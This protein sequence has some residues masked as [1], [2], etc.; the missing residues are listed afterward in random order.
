MSIR[1]TL[2]KLLYGLIHKV[3]ALRDSRNTIAKWYPTCFGKNFLFDPMFQEPDGQAYF[4]KFHCE[5]LDNPLTVNFK[6]FK[7]DIIRARH[8]AAGSVHSVQ[9]TEPSALPVAVTGIPLREST[10]SQTIKVDVEGKDLTLGDL[11]SERYYYLPISAPGTVRLSSATDMIVGNPLPLAQKK[12]HQARMVMTIFMD[13]FGWDVLNFLN[14]ERDV[15][16]LARFFSKGTVF[17]QCFSASNWT[18]A[19]VGSI[20]SG[21]STSHHNMFHNDRTDLLLGDDYKVLPEYFHDDGYLTLQVCGN[22]RKSPAYGFV[23]GYDRTVYRKDI[24]LGESLETIY[25]HVRAFPERDHFVWLTIMDVHHTIAGVPDLTNQ[26]N[27]PIEA[28]D[29][30][31]R[32]GKSPRVLGADTRSIARYVQDFKRADFYLGQLFAFLEERYGDDEMLV[33]LVSDHGPGFLSEN[34][35]L[36]SS[37]KTHVPF[38]L[39]GRNVPTLRTSE[40]IQGADIL[41]SILALNGWTSANPIDGRVPEALGG[42]PGREFVLSEIRINGEKYLATIRDRRFEFHMES[43]DRLGDEGSINLTGA[44]ITLHERDGD[45]TD[46]AGQ[47]PDMVRRYSRYLHDF[48]GLPWQDS[49]N[50]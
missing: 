17:D 3:V 34:T 8:C 48:L 50:D 4:A 13:N 43:V 47:H 18:L 28:H 30:R 49:G 5:E 41:P 35:A 11:A 25:D 39:R 16:N 31:K 37:Q 22:V 15:P 29:Y 40:L 38:M 6:R 2:N 46:I 27:V 10:A 33:A 21:R 19:S 36:L 12:R 23:K 7:T 24:G 42:D 9:V 32:K 26:L 1:S 14:L 44:T 45:K 20:V